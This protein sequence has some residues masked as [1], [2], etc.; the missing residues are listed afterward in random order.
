MVR[1]DSLKRVAM[2]KE[3]GH[4][5]P[6]KGPDSGP[7]IVTLGSEEKALADAGETRPRSLSLECIGIEP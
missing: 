3:A 6:K 1:K 2:E 5:H 4:P 7:K